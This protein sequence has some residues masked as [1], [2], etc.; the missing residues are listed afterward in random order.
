MHNCLGEHP[1]LCLPFKI[2]NYFNHDS[3]FN[4]GPEWYENHF[5]T[6]SPNQLKG[7]L[8]LYLPSLDAPRRIYD[9]DPKIKLI[10]PLRS[11]IE[12]AFASYEGELGGGAIPATM[13]FATALKERPIYTERGFYYESLKRYLDLFSPEQV[14]VTVLED[15]V[16][17][18]AGFMRRIFEFLEVDPNFEP[19]MLLE[20]V[21]VGGVPRSGAATRTMARIAANMRKMGL[22]KAMWLVKRSGAVA[23]VHKA[24]RKSTATA[25]A[26]ELRAELETLYEPDI[27]AV[28]DLLKR[29]LSQWRS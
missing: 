24:N 11:P 12:R 29:D 20:W 1:Q 23:A 4:K 14:L 3:N 22:Q 16:V 19:S 9:Y 6:C 18:P 15:G 2:V 10:F 8:S 25:M 21:S 27:V 28:E 7:E 13:D 17:D 5:R 26:P